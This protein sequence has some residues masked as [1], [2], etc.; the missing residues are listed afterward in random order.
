MQDKSS[1][2]LVVSKSVYMISKLK[3]HFCVARKSLFFHLDFSINSI[4]YLTVFGYLTLIGVQNH[5]NFTA[6]F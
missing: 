6:Q 4:G 3:G 5:T 1:F 2:H